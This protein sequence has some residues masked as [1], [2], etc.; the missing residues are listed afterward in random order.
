MNTSRLP[1]LFISHGSPMLAL[2]TVNPAHKFLKGLGTSLPHP[3]A[4]LV[5]SAHWE[6]STPR[7]TG[8]GHLDTIHDFYGFPEPLYGL[9]YPA[10]GNPALAKEI[11]GLLQP[12][13]DIDPIRGLDH[14]AW[15]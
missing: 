7:I 14:G 4:I 13:A 3:A 8:T 2:D 9:R 6:T 1:T 11:V 15:V 10:P 5:V 12:A